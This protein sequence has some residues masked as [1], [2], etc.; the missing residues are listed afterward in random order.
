MIFLI[1]FTY[2][3]QPASL[4]SRRFVAYNS[5]PE[6][7]LELVPPEDEEEKHMRH[8]IVCLTFFIGPA[9]AQTADP[10][11]RHFTGRTLRFDYYHTGTAGE[12]HVSVDR[13]RL[14]VWAIDVAS[15]RS[16]VSQPRTGFWN[17]TPIG[18]TYNAFD[19]FRDDDLGWRNESTMH[20]TAIAGNRFPN[21]SVVV[22]PDTVVA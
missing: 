2:R 8:W 19:S 9:L 1:Q 17:R 6:F 20:A 5:G 3:S 21:A 16:R 18:L 12:E 10:F 13:L 14:N 15:E 4:R 7:T 11:E 22:V